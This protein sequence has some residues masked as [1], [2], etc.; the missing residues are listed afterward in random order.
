MGYLLEA[1]AR[2]TTACRNALFLSDPATDREN[3]TTAKGKRV[4]GTCVWIKEDTAFQ[5]WQQHKTQLL[6]ISGGPGK[7]KTIMSVFLT[8]ELKETTAKDGE[9]VLY[10]FCS[11]EDNRRNS[12]TAI[13]RS[14]L[15]QLT[16][17]RK[18]LTKHLLEYFGTPQKEQET[19]SSAE[20]LWIMFL[21]LVQDARAGQILCIIDGLDECEEESTRWLAMKFSDLSS[22]DKSKNALSVIL[23]SREIRGLIRFTRIKLDP[24]NDEHVNEDID[25]FVSTRVQELSGLAGFDEKFRAAIQ[26][27]LLDRAE[28]TFLWVGFVMRELLK[29]RTCTEVE[30]SLEAFPRGLPAVYD[31]MLQQIQSSDKKTCADILLWVT[32]AIR[33]LTLAELSAAVGIQP[34]TLIKQE[35]AVLDY[36]EMCGDILKVQNGEVGLVHQSARD[37]FLFGQVG[38]NIGLEDF[39]FNAQEAHLRL[40]WACLDCMGRGLAEKVDSSVYKEFPLLDYA[41]SYWPEHATSSQSR[42]EKLF[43]HPSGFFQKVSS[44]R[45]N[46]WANYAKTRRWVHIP[47]DGSSHPQLQMACYA[48][49]VP[50]VRKILEKK[51]FLT[52]RDSVNRRDGSGKPPLSYAVRGGDTVIVRLLLERKAKINAK[53]KQGRTA[54]DSSASKGDEAMARLLLKNGADIHAR[55][56]QGYT[57]LGSAASKGHE[58]LV[59]LMLENGANINAETDEKRTALNSAASRGHESIVRFLISQG[60]VVNTKTTTEGRSALTSSASNGHE[61][62]VRLLLQNGADIHAKTNTGSTALQLAVTNGHEGA[63]RLLLQDD[64]D[65]RMKNNSGSTSLQLAAVN[66]HE[67]IVRLLLEHNVDIHAKTDSGYDALQS[68]ATYGYEEIVRMLLEHGADFHMKTEQQGYSAL[69]LAASRG[70]EAVVRLLLEK[71]ADHKV[72]TNDGYRPLDLAIFKGHVA[73]ARLLLEQGADVHAKDDKGDQ[74][75][76][77][78]ATSESEECVRLLLEHGANVNAEN[79]QGSKVL[80]IVAT[81]GNVAIARIFL[82]HGAEINSKDHSGYRPLDIAVSKD[83][84][85]MVKLLLEYKADVNA[86]DNSDKTALHVASGIGNE[87][88]IR[89]LL[90][91]GADT[92]LKDK[93][94]RIPAYYANEKAIKSLLTPT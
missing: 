40:A 26:A 57:A 67:G 89:S 91:C 65:V 42:A 74:A 55:D 60:A 68:A 52:F 85:E 13:L 33:P 34:S 80:D 59:R 79:N 69:G 28:G 25:K 30:K 36:I 12:A 81:N 11:N 78:A 22:P 35:Q 62:I 84:H 38:K 87:A 9:I 90:E 64:A 17:K 45:D 31:R 58:A 93:H 15:W 70:H 82:E 18:D 7:G 63:V 6:W 83:H 86:A 24:D 49:V 61:E 20:T 53:D 37:Y 43:L 51:S 56:K 48:V 50:W 73:T 2:A 32:V 19:L 77:S 39:R 88:I 54:L 5:R 21:R 47:T 1:I 94:G 44:V 72:Q 76:D 46:W 10:F 14:L 41:I 16:G 3:L 29:K 8:E 92:K 75:L 71:G 23:T 4:D 66:G 27:T